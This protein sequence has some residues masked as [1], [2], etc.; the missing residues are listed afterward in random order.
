MRQYKSKRYVSRVQLIKHNATKR[1]W[2]PINWE[3]ELHQLCKLSPAVDTVAGAVKVEAMLRNSGDVATTEK[4]Y[5]VVILHGNT[6]AQ[7]S[8]EIFSDDPVEW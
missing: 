7:A 1:K 2:R 3:F 6:K 5:S 8:F 4:A